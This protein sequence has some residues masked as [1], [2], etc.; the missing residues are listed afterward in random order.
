MWEWKMECT[1]KRRH[2]HV[3]FSATGLRV[4]DRSFFLW[5]STSTWYCFSGI[6]K[7]SRK[8]IYSNVK[9]M[10]WSESFPFDL[11]PLSRT[12]FK[13]YDEKKKLRARDFYFHLC[14]V[15][16]SSL[17]CDYSGDSVKDDIGCG[18]WLYCCL[19]ST[20]FGHHNTETITENYDGS[21]RRTTDPN[22]ITP[23]RVEIT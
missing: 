19:G 15:S 12:H 17:S 9:K 22:T 20:N 18:I 5:L 13:L 16:L 1:K 10:L 14:F 23:K 3:E 7:Y 21:R 6:M 8:K 4:N 2:F 11:K